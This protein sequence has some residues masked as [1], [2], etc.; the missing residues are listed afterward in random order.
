MLNGKL[1][2]LGEV[3]AE[4]L[5]LRALANWQRRRSCRL[6]PA[7]LEDAC[8]FVTASVWIASQKWDPSRSGNARA[9]LA[10]RAAFACTDWLRAK[11]KRTRWVWSSHTYEQP[12]P[13]APLS[14]DAPAHDRLN[15]DPGG[16][17]LGATL[18][19]LSSGDA[20]DRDSD[21]LGLLRERDQH[22]AQDLALLHEEDARLVAERTARRRPR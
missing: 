1:I 20:A 9:F 6:N 5:A 21:V 2:L 8:A 4:A 22:F 16:D 3:D 10:Q 15:D 19:D 13:P 7:D 11:E 18:A 17:T 12:R 14:L